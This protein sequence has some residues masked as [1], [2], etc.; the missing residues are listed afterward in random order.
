MK[1]LKLI[2]QL[3]MLLS[4]L[5]TIHNTAQNAIVGYE[6][7]FNNGEGLQF[8]AVPPTSNFNLVTDIDVS[9]L[10]NAINT[11][12]MR[13]IDD[14]GLW[15]PIV[16][17][18]FVKP[19]E[20]FVNA[21]TIVGYEY[22]FSDD[23][24]PT[25]VSISSTAS[26]NLISDFDVSSMP[27]DVN[28]FHIRFQDDLGQWSPIISK[29][30]VKPPKTFTNASNIIG[31]EY[32]FDDD[33]PPVYVPVSPT[34]SYNLVSDF[35]VSSLSNDV[36]IFH[37]RFQDDLGQWSPIISKIF[38][39]PPDT[40]ASASNI[41]GYEYAFNDG[42]NLQ[43]ISI[44]PTASFNLVTDIDV[45]GLT[46]NINTLH[47]R[48]KDDLG[49][50]SSML[51]KVFVKS[52]EP[53]TLPNNVL[54]SYDYW[55]NDNTASVVTTTIEPAQA[56]YTLVEIDV[57]Q[58]WAGEYRL[59]TQFKDT[60][61]NYSV[62][63]TDTINKAILPL[64]QFT[65]DVL[66]IC[67]GTTVN[68][69][70]TSID[71]DDQLWDFD[72]GNTSN[73]VNASHTFNTPGTYDVS[74]SIEDTSTGLTDVAS[75]TIEV[76]ETPT[77]TITTSTSL[78]ACFGEIVTLTA[79][80]ENGTYLWSN[81]AT[82]QSIEVT[83]D[84]EYSVEISNPNTTLCSV[85]S[86]IINITFS[87][88]I[89]ATVSSDATTITASLAGASY[90]WIDCSNGN[91]AI[92][93]ETNQSFAPT[94]D[95]DYAVEITV[96]GCTV[97]S[98]CVTMSNLSSEDFNLKTMVKL[99]PNPTKNQLQILT[100][101]DIT[102]EVYST[103]GQLITIIEQDTGNGNLDMSHYENG[104]YLFIVKATKDSIN[105]RNVFRIIKN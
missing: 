101:L 91:I 90:Q 3:W 21:S 28:I 77:N 31:Y 43:Y 45:N 22:A 34:A 47:I 68:F 80:Y 86:N 4:L 70:N 25:Y 99:Y 38:I 35:D 20:T 36:N 52:P 26:Y 57:S 76:Y 74:L 85:T 5:F 88:E 30:F 49:Q 29:V 97:T 100:E 65:T 58:L 75:Q 89:D 72:D 24:P 53:A 78:P 84:G 41:V 33:N 9:T 32:G 2:P 93:G 82:T 71:F 61:G 16:S 55:F 63:M 48:F 60:Y 64:A 7:A 50:W 23:N 66:E 94:V 6:Y 11:V 46:N 98:E 13:F 42:E 12:H 39:K 81:G 79:D 1:A 14:N 102:I 95:G 19:P 15:S 67:T 87:P 96:N 83:A 73:M 69:T 18:V 27:N 10:T 56:N 92:V 105:K 44:S 62:V 59:N 8:V 104:M 54:V 17:K 103:L 51:S 40:F 37:I